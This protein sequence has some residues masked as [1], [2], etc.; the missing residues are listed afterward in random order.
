MSWAD[1]LFSCELSP[2]ETLDKNNQIFIDTGI[3]SEYPEHP[4]CKIKLPCFMN[5]WA[6][7]S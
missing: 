5:L 3:P 4:N 2:H 6:N 1:W 7:E